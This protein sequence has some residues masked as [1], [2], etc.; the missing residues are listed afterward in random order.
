MRGFKPGVYIGKRRFRPYRMP[1]TPAFL[2]DP[3][4]IFLNIKQWQIQSF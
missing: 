4:F 1:S 3:H 2:P